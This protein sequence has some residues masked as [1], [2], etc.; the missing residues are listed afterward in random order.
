MLIDA[1]WQRDADTCWRA[2][3]CLVLLPVPQIGLGLHSHTA[4][5]RGRGVPSAFQRFFTIAP[6]IFLG[7][8]AALF[9]LVEILRF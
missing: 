1:I 2:K 4:V 8:A 9:V 3:H 5:L 7:I 6:R